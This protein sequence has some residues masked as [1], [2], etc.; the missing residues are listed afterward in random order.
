[1]GVLQS[2]GHAQAQSHQPCGTAHLLAERARPCATA[3]PV[4]TPAAQACTAVV[5]VPAVA[6]LVE[7][8][9]V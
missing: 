4:P 5:V 2:A 3:P 1:M 7:A 6:A 8:A 9:N